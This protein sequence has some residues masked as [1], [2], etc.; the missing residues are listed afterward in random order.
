RVDRNEPRACFVAGVLGT[1]GRQN[2]RIY[3]SVDELLGILVRERLGVIAPS[4]PELDVVCNAAEDLIEADPL[5]FFAVSLNRSIVPAPPS[6]TLELLETFGSPA[7]V[8][9]AG[10]NGSL[11]QR[12]K[13]LMFG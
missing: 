9:G 7:E 13:F 11:C 3:V 10:E 12:T 1:T 4:F 2:G 5:I 6:S 8:Q